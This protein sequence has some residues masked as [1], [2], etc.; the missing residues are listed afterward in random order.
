LAT[1][2]AILPVIS[3][4]T[5]PI[6]Q[7]T[8]QYPMKRSEVN[9]TATVQAV[10]RYKSDED[11]MGY[12]TGPILAASSS[13]LTAAHGVAPVPPAPPN[14]TSEECTFPRYNT[15]G[16]CTRVNNITSA[17]SVK[18]ITN[19]TRADWTTVQKSYL[20]QGAYKDLDLSVAYNASLPGR[21][22]HMVNPFPAGISICG[23]PGSMAEQDEDFRRA[24]F[25][26][27]AVIAGGPRGWYLDD[28]A[29]VASDWKDIQHQ[30]YEIN[31]AACVKTFE[32]R[33]VDGRPKMEVV[34]TSFAV[35]TELSQRGAVRCQ[36]V[37]FSDN[38]SWYCSTDY[39]HRESMND[40]TPLM[41][42][43]D[44]LDPENRS[45]DANDYYTIDL[46][47]LST[48]STLVNMLYAAI[49]TWE[50]ATHQTSTTNSMRVDTIWGDIIT[51]LS[52]TNDTRKQMTNLQ[53]AANNIATAY[54]NGYVPSLLGPRSCAHA[55]SDCSLLRQCAAHRTR[56]R[57]RAP[58]GHR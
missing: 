45:L 42:L 57:C 8:I 10:R 39:M 26:S 12:G 11:W 7:Q 18:K 14:C 29:L 33:F 43:K 40:S 16:I 58:T 21:V 36:P 49:W 52:R 48:I 13:G 32:A 9:G 25:F 27:I 23:S 22:C 2:G 4:V 5:S 46:Y 55:L 37:S 3:I 20:D 30:A 1:L 51:Y 17:L 44:P 54:T 34:A 38:D 28:N 31:L 56:F 19:S 53:L 35:K 24:N 41:V 6:T 15:L 50:A 47:S